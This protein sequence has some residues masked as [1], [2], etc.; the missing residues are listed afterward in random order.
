MAM[1][2]APMVWHIDWSCDALV[3][4]MMVGNRTTAREAYATDDCTHDGLY[5][6]L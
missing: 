4:A 3:E 6:G 5:A 1:R 2:T